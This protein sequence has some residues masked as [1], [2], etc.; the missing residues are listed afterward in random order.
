MLVQRR[1]PADERE[2]LLGDLTESYHDRVALAGGVS[3]RR[4]FWRETV[5]LLLS[6]WPA[7]RAR[8]AAP[9]PQDT[10]MNTLLRDLQFAVRTLVRAPG[11]SL[12]TILTLAM[13]IGATSAIFGVVRPALL[14]PPR[15]ADPARLA[16]VFE[17]DRDGGE[18]NM[19]WLT[20]KD[21]ERDSRTLDAAAA[22]SY[23][24]PILS[25][26]AE[27]ERLNGQSVTHRFFD[28]LGVQP[29]LGR[30][31]VAAE[32]LPGA[33]RVAVL[34]HALWLRRF[35][36]D[37]S[38]VGR[39]VPVNGVTF[40]V[41]GVLPPDF[42]SVLAPGTDIWRPLGYEASQGW[43]C[44]TCRHLR[45]IARVRAGVAREAAWRELEGLSVSLTRQFPDQYAAPG[46]VLTPLHDYVTRQARPALWA[47]V[48]A[49]A[50]VALIACANA[51]NLLLGRALRREPEFAIRT[52]LG[53]S[54]RRLVRLVASE[55][56][57]LAVV[58]GSL[59]LLL[60]W[61]GVRFFLAMAPQGIPRLDQVR[62]DGPVAGFTFLLALVAGLA[63]S[64]LPALTT[65]RADLHGVIKS[66]TRGLASRS[67]R[68]RGSLVVAETALA[69]TLLA[70]ATLLFQSLSRLLGV[71]A[72][73]ETERMLTMETQL[74]GPRYQDSGAVHRT[75]AVMLQAVRA[76]PGVEAAGFAS[77][78]PLGGNVDMYGIHL[79]DRPS[80]NPEQDPSA[81]RYAVTPDYLA[82]MGIPLLRGRGIT[83]ADVETTPYAV[84][85]NQSMA[86]T[87]FAGMDPI[88]RRLRMGGTDG[89]WR[90]VVGIVG[91]ALHRGL[92]APDEPQVY[93]P[94]TQWW[95]ETG[96]TL[97][98]RAR[99][100][101]LSLVPTVRAAVASADRTVAIAKVATMEQ[102]LARS[103]SQRRFALVL[104]AVFAGIALLLTAFGIYG[105][106]AA[107]VAERTRE[108]GIRSALGA[109]QSRILGMV[110]RQG[111]ALAGAGLVLGLGGALGLSKLL[112]KLLYGVRPENPAA[113]LT[114]TFALA[115][116]A[117]V[118]CAV[119]AW[120]ASRVDP[121]VALRDG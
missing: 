87:I 78:L 119:P 100:V 59:G 62:V 2:F 66:G 49:V 54:R 11:L 58:A 19:G 43:A 45:V 13:G 27:S 23:W 35:G 16:L 50:F 99:T 3:A 67:H 86:E 105:V 72:G 118:A 97:V 18:S 29:M 52:A 17:R 39:G 77:Q 117:V 7:T 83:A 95:E 102:L 120:R 108:I 12:S 63:A 96:M 46:V 76:V 48:A 61:G 5:R 40:T 68:L 15:Y 109:P 57:M 107:S 20:F 53:A 115:A 65:G 10:S 31:F 56:V 80:A 84:V 71:N 26:E 51:A 36:G 104:F 93:V 111:A 42:E 114:V 112:A 74:S 89:P 44:R 103:T 22:I 69:V 37:R 33:N 85:I 25:G 116:V 101:P 88:G 60:A 6:P 94:V 34:S 1:V 106:L 70:G 14:E 55:S 8:R 75:Q 81:M 38:I 4:W 92:D 90:T 9:L 64:V 79:E 24:Q 32:D 113:L 82:A 110:V 91:N 73:F 30:G 121:M 21:I 47:L 28:V 41:V 98:V